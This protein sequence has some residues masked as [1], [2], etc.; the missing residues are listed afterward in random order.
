[1]IS[2]EGESYF[3]FMEVGF[4]QTV[5]GTSKTGQ[6]RCPDLSAIFIVIIEKG[7]TESSEKWMIVLD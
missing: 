2:D 3:M 7:T 6:K 4:L 1:M 5:K